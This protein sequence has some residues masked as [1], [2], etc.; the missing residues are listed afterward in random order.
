M[1]GWWADQAGRAGIW[2]KQLVSVKKEMCDLIICNFGM[3]CSSNIFIDSSNSYLINK[4]TVSQIVQEHKK[5]DILRLN[6]SLQ[7]IHWVLIA[8]IDEMGCSFL[9]C[10]LERTS[11]NCVL[12][13][14][15]MWRMRQNHIPSEIQTLQ[16]YLLCSV[17]KTVQA[18][19]HV[20]RM[21]LKIFLKLRSLI[22]WL[23]F[24]RLFFNASSLA[25]H[26][27]PGTIS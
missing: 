11:A 10:C 20:K 1:L 9:L 26:S 5:S 16:S 23:F 7:I 15:R 24:L 25:T 18:V 21:N 17:Y 2:E 4:Y 14:D 6:Y 13:L 12:S 22:R 19:K 3:E 8:Q 27:A